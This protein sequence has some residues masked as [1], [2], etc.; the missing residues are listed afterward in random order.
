M[1]DRAQILR[2]SSASSLVTVKYIAGDIGPTEGAECRLQIAGGNT[3]ISKKKGKDDRASEGPLRASTPFTLRI[4]PSFLHIH[5]SSLFL[6]PPF[7]PFLLISYYWVTSCFEPHSF[8]TF[9]SPP[10]GHPAVSLSVAL[11]HGA[12]SYLSSPCLVLRSPGSSFSLPLPFVALSLFGGGY[13]ALTAKHSGTSANGY[14][15][16]GDSVVTAFTWCSSSVRI[17]SKPLYRYR[18][19][20]SSMLPDLPS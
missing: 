6:A 20:G 13:A 12:I 18:Q 14:R 5:F 9:F 15:V 2:P 17:N 16:Q 19:T 4:S 1:C 7:F 8:P 3:Q 10:S 11:L